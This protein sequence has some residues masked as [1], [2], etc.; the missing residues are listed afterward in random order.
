MQNKLEGHADTLNIDITYITYMIK[1]KYKNQTN[2][3]QERKNKT[4]KHVL[5]TKLQ[6]KETSRPENTKQNA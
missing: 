3:L 5:H 4:L 2:K 1:K 6:N